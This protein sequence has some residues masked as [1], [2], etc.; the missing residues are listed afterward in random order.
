MAPPND[1]AVDAAN[2]EALRWISAARPVLRRLR[3]AGELV[4]GLEPGLVLHAGPP[5]A[6]L[7]ECCAALRGSIAGSRV[8]QSADAI[9]GAVTPFDESW[10][11]A[12]RS[13]H[14]FGAVGT[15]AGVITSE[16]PVFEVVDEATGI[17]AFA[18]INEGRGAALR[19][20]STDAKTLA[21]AR[22]LSSG[23]A[24]VIDHALAHA[25]PIDLFAIMEQA[26]QM[27][28]ELHSRQKAA[29]TLLLAQLAPAIATAADDSG[30][31]ARCFRFLAEND[32]FF[33]PLAMAAAKTAMAAADGISGSTIVTAIAFNG[34]RCG[35]RIAGQ[36]AWYVAPVPPV[37]GHFFSGFAAQDAGPTIGDSEIMESMGLGGLSLAAAPALA[38]HLAGRASFGTELTGEMYRICAGENPVFRIP[39]LEFRGAP[40]GIDVRKV[41]ATGIAPAFN[42]GIAHRD[43]GVGQIGAG[44]GR[45]PLEC[46]RAALEADR[47][48]P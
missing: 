25:G 7:H 42:T 45:V 43:S 47:S 9:D 16:T 40:L 34:V 29:S 23:F 31:V 38:R 21:R 14:D 22:W 2:S 36:D 27:G 1:G 18:A 30:Q 15:F 46:F 8:V 33:L 11:L 4:R 32:F 12:L 3:R 28:D 24:Q 41:V 5:L 13:A 19:Y 35:I 39:A 48:R 37:D 17:R 44:F 10:P 6:G 26:L 20:G